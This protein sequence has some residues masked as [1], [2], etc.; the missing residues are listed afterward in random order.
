MA[1]VFM[2]VVGGGLVLLAGGVVYLG[3]F[4]PSPHQ[5]AVEKVI[6]NDIFK[7]N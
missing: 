1:R 4:P 5:Q 3:A 2:I 7:T 6:S